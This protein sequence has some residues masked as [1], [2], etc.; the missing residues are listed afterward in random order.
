MNAPAPP[1]EAPRRDLYSNLIKL[2]ELRKR[3]L[4][5][6]A[7]FEEQKTLLLEATGPRN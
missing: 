1:A 2:D 5:T 4:L 7:E 3:G 6:E